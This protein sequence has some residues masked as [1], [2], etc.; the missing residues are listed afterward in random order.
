MSSDEIPA[1]SV[2]A[3]ARV[4]LLPNEAGVGKVPDALIVRAEQLC[5]VLDAANEARPDRQAVVAALIA[6]APEDPEA[7]AALMKEY[8][9]KRVRDVILGG[10]F[11]GPIDLA[12]ELSEAKKRAD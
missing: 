12:A 8:R 5:K 7:L 1:G 3:D 10:K 9:G 11:S 6:V 2:D 4:Q